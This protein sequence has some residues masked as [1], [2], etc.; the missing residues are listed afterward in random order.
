MNTTFLL[1]GGN[2]GDRAGHLGKAVALIRQ[3]IGKIENI[4]AI[5]ETAAWGKI[6]QPDY[7]N[8]VVKV[9]T[10]L[11]PQEA[12]KAILSIENDMGR[13]RKKVWE[14]RLIDI[15]ILFYNEDIIREEHL[16]IPHPHLQDRRF[17][18][19]PLA[20]I[21]PAFVHPVLKTTI[22]ELLDKCPDNLRVKQFS[23]AA[24]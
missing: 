11:Q 24:I 6:D 15:D 23:F 22:K 12:L 2:L 3:R 10:R 18:L 17:V 19:V 1:I 5:Y 14:P 16:R 21:S 7:L 4:S 13:I 20:E 9:S 8:Q